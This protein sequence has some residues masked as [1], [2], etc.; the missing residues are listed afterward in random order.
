[1]SASDVEVEELVTAEEDPVLEC[2]THQERVCHT[3]H[4]THYT[5][6]R[7]K[8]RRV[9]LQTNQQFSFISTGMAPTIFRRL[10]S[11]VS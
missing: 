8:V 1:M 7:G 10:F 3:T 11:I 4:T 9:D 6:R 2:V 5:A